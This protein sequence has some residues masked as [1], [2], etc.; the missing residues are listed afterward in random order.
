M[1]SPTVTPVILRYVIRYVPAFEK[2]WNRFARPVHKSWRV[3]ET[4]INIRGKWNF[5]YRAVDR[6][7]KTGD[8]LLR[9]NRTIA[10][11]QA[12][13]RKALSTTCCLGH[14]R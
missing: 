10:A 7:G 14:A 2:R 5:L 6:H 1:P 3:D 8:Y 12:F 13:F 11:A 9:P 4:Y